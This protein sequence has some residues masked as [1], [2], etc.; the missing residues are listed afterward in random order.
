MCTAQRV[1]LE[2]KAS[3]AGNVAG[4]CCNGATSDTD[5]RNAIKKG[6]CCPALVLKGGMLPGLG[7]K[8]GECC[9]ALVLNPTCC[10]MGMLLQGL[11]T[12]TEDSAIELEGVEIMAPPSSSGARPDQQQLLVKDLT[13]RI[14]PGH[15]T[16]IRGQVK[17]NSAAPVV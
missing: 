9:P 3:N 15:H 17:A 4:I 10:L 11:Y 13:L 7:A 16:V 14:E 6:E 12:G 5:M 2:P 8:K 1:P